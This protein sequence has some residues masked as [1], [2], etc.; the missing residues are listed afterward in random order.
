MDINF[1]VPL[2]VNA[3]GLYLTHR[4]VR[5]MEAQAGTTPLPKL[6]LRIGRYWPIVTMFVLMLACWIPYFL[7]G[8]P[9]QNVMMNY[10]MRNG[11]T[12]FVQVETNELVRRKSDQLMII[13]RIGDISVNFMN[14][15][16]IARSGTFEITSPVTNM[17]VVLP[18]DFL[19]R[20]TK[21]PYMID[22][23]V[24]EV[25]EDFPIE[26][27]KSIAEAEKR[28]AKQLADKSFGPVQLPPTQPPLVQ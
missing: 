17:E 12:V 14:D 7:Q 3:I 4:Q 9:Q 19:E 28:G 27:V 5:F 18:K 23:Y 10:G 22:V 8:A 15:T 20:L 13:A 2:G 25:P 21:Y 26:S 6:R 24:F 11:K 1:W 16:T